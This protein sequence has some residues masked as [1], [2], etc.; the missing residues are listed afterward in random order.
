MRILDD[1]SDKKLDT[2]SI[3]LTKNEARQLVAYLNALLQNP[4]LHHQHLSSDDYKKE[5]TV[6]VYD[7]KK[8][9]GFHQRA[10][11]LIEKDE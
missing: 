4:Q 5:V 9:E 2:V 7:E 1:E 10:I 3:F 11:K 6:C 8:L